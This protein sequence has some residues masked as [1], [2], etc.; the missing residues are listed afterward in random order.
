MPKPETML[1]IIPT[2]KRNE[3]LPAVLES[4]KL[5]TSREIP[6]R[7]RVAVI[8]NH[9]PSADEVSG[10]VRVVSDDKRFEWITIHR[11]VTLDPVDNW[12][13]AVRDLALEDEVVLLHG[14]DDLFTPWSLDHRVIAIGDTDFLL[15]KFLSRLY[16]GEGG[17]SVLFTGNIPTEIK[18]VVPE[19]WSTKHLSEFEPSFLG[20]HCYRNTA[21][22]RLALE[23]C[24]RV[25]D[26][27]VWVDRRNRFLMFPYY[28]PFAVRMV[29]GSVRVLDDPCV[30]R[31]ASLAEI[32]SA[33]FGV[34]A[35]NTCFVDLCAYER[36]ASGAFDGSGI[37]RADVLHR[38]L[39]PIR[40]ASPTMFFDS[41]LPY[42][43]V[44]ETLRRAGLSWNIMLRVDSLAGWK[45]V[46]ASLL[47]LRN[48]KIKKQFKLNAELT[49]Q[50]LN[51]L[52]T[53]KNN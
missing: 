53:V 16:F 22:F 27:Q 4:L 20:N 1:V 30:I 5:A 35:W 34:S 7:V 49:G 32:C 50:F 47:R 45:T 3:C 9:P 11:K 38:F 36:F 6:D 39:R 40:A 23:L 10:I 28:L 26:E 51:K 2:Y 31:G 19:Q 41:R 52:K 29:G 25:C 37:P 21:R 48:H 42:K 46:V 8:N 18:S 13:S 17:R 43:M 15:T 12:Y 44:R 33:P 24:T 14:D